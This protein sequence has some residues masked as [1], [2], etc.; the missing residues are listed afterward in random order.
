MYKFK[1]RMKKSLVSLK[2]RS[3]M[4]IVHGLL[5]IEDEYQVKYILL[6]CFIFAV[7]LMI[8]YLLK[9]KM[10]S[11]F[12]FLLIITTTTMVYWSTTLKYKKQLKKIKMRNRSLKKERLM[13]FVCQTEQFQEA[14]ECSKFQEAKN[15][16]YKINDVLLTR[17]SQ[18]SKKKTKKV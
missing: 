5:P 1:D 10:V 9:E 2:E 12:S 7:L 17:L 11:L 3:W 15:N 8:Y 13:D 16:F 14:M 4:E 6:L 18:E